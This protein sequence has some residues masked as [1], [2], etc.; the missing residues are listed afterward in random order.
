MAIHEAVQTTVI[1][2]RFKL[3]RLT[4]GAKF[5]DARAS[6]DVIIQKNLKYYV[7]VSGRQ[8][9][10]LN[11]HSQVMTRIKYIIKHKYGFIPK[12]NGHNTPYRCVSS[13]C[14]MTTFSK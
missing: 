3:Q 9:E 12:A 14:Q 13:L 11:L 6:F 1:F 7:L 8:V 2:E 10:L 4:R 5:N